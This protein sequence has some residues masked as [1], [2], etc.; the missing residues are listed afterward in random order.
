MRRILIMPGGGVMGIISLAC[1]DAVERQMDMP[2]YELADLVVGSSI[3]GLVGGAVASGRL[4]AAEM[5]ET[6][7]VVIPQAFKRRF[8]F[9]PK[10]DRAPVTETFINRVGVG[11]KMSGC[12]T[13]LVVTAVRARDKTNH[14][15]KSWQEKD[16]H[17]PLLEA[18]TRTYAAPVY[19]GKW[20]TPGTKEVWLDGGTGSMNTPI[21]VGIWE[22]V[23]QGWLG[24]DRVHVLSVG[25]GYTPEVTSWDKL[26][27]MRWLREVCMYLDPADGGMARYQSRND[28]VKAAEDLVDKVPGFTFQHVDVRVPKR[29]NRMDGVRYMDRYESYG[30]QMATEV[31]YRKLRR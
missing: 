24:N 25:T 30:R 20:R 11:F 12:V 14:F 18:V 22:A 16:G 23:R 27:R 19:F 5:L 15:F 28:N 4:T 8:R 31:D 17:L 26:R 2:L 13:R 10:Y 7:R 9:Y 3:G 21:M 1:W 6:C 29:E